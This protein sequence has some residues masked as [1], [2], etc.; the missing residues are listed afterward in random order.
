M[1]HGPPSRNLPRA[2]F[3]AQRAFATLQRFLH[4]E[5]SGA[6]MLLLA[7]AAALIVSNSRFATFYNVL[8]Q[9]PLGIR[10]GP[11]EVDK[12]LLLWIND[13]LMAVFFFLVGLEIKRELLRGE[14]STFG[15]AVLPALA[16]LG[17]MAVPAAMYVAINVGDATAL[18]GWA[19]PTTTDIAFS[20]G[21]LALLGGRVPT[22]LKVFLLA[23]AIIDDLGAIL[24]IALFYTE[25]LSWS[26]LAP[27]AVGA[28]VLCALNARGV[29]RAAPYILVGIFI[30][31]CVLESGVHATLAGVVV[32]LAIPLGKTTPERAS[33]LER[34]AENLHRWV[35]FAV[36]PLFAFV[37]AGVSLQGLS[38]VKLAEPI[39]LGIVAGLFPGKMLGIL[40]ATWLAVAAG[41]AQKPAGASW[42]QICGLAVLGGIGFTMSLFIGMLA[43][44]DPAH[45]AQLRLGVLAGSVASAV[46]GYLLLANFRGTE[47][48][49]G[50]FKS[51]GSQPRL[52]GSER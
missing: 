50:D 23:L 19:I 30:W 25:H 1:D 21:V 45:A 17:G 12:P 39:T 11:L 9:V 31:L 24:I 18:R 52:P 27:A 34:L 49:P 7:A 37:N 26:M 2:Q 16:A 20:V 35:A 44:D 33:L 32:A 51:P 43:F 28:V 4:V 22:S 10:L 8:L 47:A 15:Q 14:L 6:I 41:L 3:F 48:P 13:G 46:V 36:L 42:A 40:G 5:A 29:L 38:L